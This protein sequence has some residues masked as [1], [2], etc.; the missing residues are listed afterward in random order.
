MSVGPSGAPTEVDMSVPEV[1]ANGEKPALKVLL[2]SPRGF[3]AGVVRAIDTVEQALAKPRAT[4][5]AGICK[6][7]IKVLVMAVLL[8]TRVRNEG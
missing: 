2:C 3:C 7:P 8:L 4:H 6:R 5:S 1:P